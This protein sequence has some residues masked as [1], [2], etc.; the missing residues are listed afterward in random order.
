[1]NLLPLALKVI[2]KLRYPVIMLVV[3]LAVADEDVIIISF[4]NA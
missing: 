3:F 4:N 2:N 1:M